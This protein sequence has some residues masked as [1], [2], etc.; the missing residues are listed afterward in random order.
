MTKGAIFLIER[1]G[2]DYLAQ[3]KSDTAIYPCVGVRDEGSEAA[4]QNAFA[5]GGWEKVTRLY[6]TGEVEEERCWVRCP[7]WTLA[8]S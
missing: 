8:Y 7:D 1:K 2:D 6:R 4:L 5:R 3:G